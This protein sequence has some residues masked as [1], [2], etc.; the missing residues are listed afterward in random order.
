MVFVQAKCAHRQFLIQLQRIHGH[1]P[2]I[3][4]IMVMRIQEELPLYSEHGKLCLVRQVLLSLVRYAERQPQIIDCSRPHRLKYN[5]T[6][7]S[8]GGN[9]ARL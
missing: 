3:E 5:E 2:V 1:Q 9:E 6:G 7:I 4:P 8:V